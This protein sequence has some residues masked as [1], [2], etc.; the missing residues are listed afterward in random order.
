MDGF[1]VHCCKCDSGFEIDP[2]AVTCPEC[3][4]KTGGTQPTSTNSSSTKLADD[5]YHIVCQIEGGNYRCA[6]TNL[7]DIVSQLRAG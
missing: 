7:R 6:Y 5:L 1:M 4:T 2:D 3:A